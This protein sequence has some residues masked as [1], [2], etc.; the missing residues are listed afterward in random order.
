MCSYAMKD[1]DVIT[2]LDATGA[3]TKMSQAVS[4]SLQEHPTMP[5]SDLAAMYAGLISFSSAVY[6]S[7][8]ENIDNVLLMCYQVRRTDELYIY[9]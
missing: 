7:K 6:A 1:P 3:F 5:A 4:K 2:Q 8:V 9:I